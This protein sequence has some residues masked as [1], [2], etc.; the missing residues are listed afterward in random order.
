MARHSQQHLLNEWDH[1]GDVSWQTRIQTIHIHKT[2]LSR[3]Q[4]NHDFGCVTH[5]QCFVEQYLLYLAL[6]QVKN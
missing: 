3:S 5:I 2:S 6:F 1:A 4:V